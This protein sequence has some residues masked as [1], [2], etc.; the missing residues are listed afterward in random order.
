MK[1]V[2]RASLAFVLSLGFAAPVSAGEHQDAQALD[3]EASPRWAPDWHAVE[4]GLAR[5][6]QQYPIPSEKL[7]PLPIGAIATSRSVWLVGSWPWGNY[8]CPGDY[9]QLEVEVRP[10]ESEYLGSPT[11]IGSPARCLPNT[12]CELQAGVEIPLEVAARSFKWQARLF[13]GTQRQ[14]CNV[15]TGVCTCLERR[16]R[17][18]TWAQFAA[19]N[20]A[21]VIPQVYA[22][23][24]ADIISPRVV[25]GQIVSGSFADLA[26]DD[27]KYLTLRR[28]GTPK[29]PAIE[30]NVQLQTNDI[31]KLSISTSTR[32]NRNCTQLIEALRVKENQWVPIN[33]QTT[34]TNRV[35]LRSMAALGNVLDYV[36]SS[37]ETK[38]G[39]AIFRISCASTSMQQHD[40]RLDFLQVTYAG[41]IFP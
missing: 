19:G 22:D 15:N 32:S 21:F 31:T 7:G 36:D 40:F 41:G 5:N 30:F 25:G 17:R 39:V 3:S 1:I 29:N 38:G 8:N 34:G 9:A 14:S 28:G 4:T 37:P 18:T 23:S 11:H 10:Y 12:N 24:T 20:P 13:L 35:V 2:A 16:V 27:N 26:A 33:Q 6:L